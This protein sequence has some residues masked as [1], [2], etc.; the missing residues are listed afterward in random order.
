MSPNSGKLHDHLKMGRLGHS[1][2]Q[3]AFLHA[4]L[5]VS[6][7]WKISKPAGQ[8]EI[9]PSILIAIMAR[10]NLQQ[11]ENNKRPE[12]R[13]QRWRIAEGHNRIRLLRGDRVAF[14]T[15]FTSL[16]QGCQSSQG[17]CINR[18]SALET[19][20]FAFDQNARSTWHLL[21]DPFAWLICSSLPFAAK[22]AALPRIYVL[23]I[24]FCE[25]RR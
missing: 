7:D 14:F 25:K 21:H 6:F 23:V 22:R 13:R 16:F 3:P 18:N 20:D 17:T 11:R 2:T 9:H 4:F 1:A 24:W 8:E 5:K 19:A 15:G 10:E 12:N